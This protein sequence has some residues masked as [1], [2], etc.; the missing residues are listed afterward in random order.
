MA[1]C[2]KTYC[3][4]KG[5]DLQ[6]D[7]KLLLGW[8]SH[9]TTPSCHH[10]TLYSSHIVTLPL[11]L[12]STPLYLADTCLPEGN[13]IQFLLTCLCHTFFLPTIILSFSQH[14]F[15]LLYLTR[16]ITAQ[17][18]TC[19]EIK[20]VGFQIFP[21]LNCSQLLYFHYGSSN[22]FLYLLIVK[23]EMSENIKKYALHFPN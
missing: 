19:G 12:Y 15:N 16:R 18:H 3:I 23:P 21:H 17:L 9:A 14:S 13:K 10:L 22:Y 20:L 2:V 7:T 5:H 11:A 4:R 8:A 1:G 6:L